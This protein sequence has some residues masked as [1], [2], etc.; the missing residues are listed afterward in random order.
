[1]SNDFFKIVLALYFT[2]MFFVV[3]CSLWSSLLLAVRKFRFLGQDNALRQNRGNAGKGLTTVNIALQALVVL[4]NPHFDGSLAREQALISLMSRVYLTESTLAISEAAASNMVH[5]Q[6]RGR[7]TDVALVLITTIC[8]SLQPSRYG[9]DWA[10]VVWHMGSHAQASTRACSLGLLVGETI[11]LHDDARACLQSLIWSRS[12][13]LRD[14]L[15]AQGGKHVLR[16]LIEIERGAMCYLGRLIA[17]T[18]PYLEA[19][20]R[21][22]L[23]VLLS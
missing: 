11:S 1:M 6:H 9:L 17:I 2:D 5:T 18:W 7:S 22:E 4:I 16:V 3:V 8:L 13:I 10:L 19:L 23:L 20:L 14:G 15:R 12:H 21:E